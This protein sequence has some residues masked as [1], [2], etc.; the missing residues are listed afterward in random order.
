MPA[1]GFHGTATAWRPTDW[2]WPNRALPV[3]AANEVPQPNSMPLWAIAID[4]GTISTRR[5]SSSSLSG[6]VS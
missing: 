2:I 6:D 5:T 1:P 4:G 3:R